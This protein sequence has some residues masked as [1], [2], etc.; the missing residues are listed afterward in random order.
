[1]MHHA[2]PAVREIKTYVIRGRYSPMTRKVARLLTCDVRFGVVVAFRSKFNVS[3]NEVSIGV[4]AQ[5]ALV[6][7]NFVPVAV[8]PTPID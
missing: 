1:M 7:L 5:C 2:R 8:T 3:I 4:A 6:F